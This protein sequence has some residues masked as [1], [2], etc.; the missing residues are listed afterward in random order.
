MISLGTN[1]TPSTCQE[2][3]IAY[4]N[5]IVDIMQER[6]VLPVLSTKAANAEGDSSG[7]LGMAQVAYDRHLPLWNFWA[8]VQDLPNYGLDKDRENVYLNY[9]GWDIRNLA[10]LDLLDSLRQQLAAAE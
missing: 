9:R 1:W 7:H 6:G 4:L 5:Q 10:A 8:T 3:Y 2:D